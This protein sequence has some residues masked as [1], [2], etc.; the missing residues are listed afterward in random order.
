[1]SGRVDALIAVT[2]V[3][4]GLFGPDPE[5]DQADD[6][7]SVVA[8][9]ATVDPQAPLAVRI[10]PRTLDEVVGQSLLLAPERRCDAWSTVVVH[11]PKMGRQMCT[12]F[13]ADG[14]HPV[15]TIDEMVEMYKGM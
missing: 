7:R 11:G 2:D 8:G 4:P 13:T 3:E 9:N 14:I 5:P 6:G 12:E 10:R 15:R 1:V